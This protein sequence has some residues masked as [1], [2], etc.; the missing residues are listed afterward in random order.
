MSRPKTTPEL[1]QWLRDCSSGVYRPSA[2][3]AAL[4]EQLQRTVTQLANCIEFPTPEANARQIAAE[5][6][7]LVQP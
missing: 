5:A 6:R 3:A 2:D 1:C 7:K 4:I